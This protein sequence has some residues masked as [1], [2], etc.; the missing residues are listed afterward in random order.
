MRK[1]RCFSTCH[2]ADFPLARRNGIVPEPVSHCGIRSDRR[3]GR[4]GDAADLSSGA[5]AR[6]VVDM[7]S[8]ASR[9]RCPALRPGYLTGLR[10]ASGRRREIPAHAATGWYLPLDGSSRHRFGV[11]VF[12]GGLGDGC[13]LLWYLVRH[14]ANVHGELITVR[15]VIA[16]CEREWLALLIEGCPADLEHGHAPVVRQ[17]EERGLSRVW[18]AHRY[19]V[20]VADL[21]QAELRVQVGHSPLRDVGRLNELDRASFDE[22]HRVERCL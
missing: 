22:A 10:H 21:I 17:L 7:T 19:L 16:D 15:G 20:A 14:A 6:T 12:T 4:H 3:A 13:S 2:E 9:L 18:R 11:P 8:P 1:R 5:S